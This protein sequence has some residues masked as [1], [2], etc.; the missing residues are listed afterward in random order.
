MLGELGWLL[1]V[2]D[3]RRSLAAHVVR[4]KYGEGRT[5]GQRAT[6]CKR[7]IGHYS[8][9]TRGGPQR[10]TRRKSW[11]QLDNCQ[12]FL[13]KLLQIRVQRALWPSQ[14]NFWLPASCGKR[15]REREDWSGLVTHQCERVHH[16]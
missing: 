15:S 14:G 3:A 1:H 13:C 16:Q 9:I 12:Q 2:F 6:P 10:R 5:C 11:G 4:A 8:K 7:K